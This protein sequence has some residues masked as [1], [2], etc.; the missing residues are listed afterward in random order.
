MT[1][2]ELL[3]MLKQTSSGIAQE[4]EFF[5]TVTF[6]VIFASYAV[7]NKLGVFPRIVICVLYL[8]S[9]LIFMLRYE[10]LSNQIPLFQL[11]LAEIGSEYMKA[12]PAV[13]IIGILRRSIMVVGSIV[14]V[15]I[16]FRPVISQSEEK[17]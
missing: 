11:G 15:Y 14:T 1:E 6:A 4:F 3:E 17:D 5:L 2:F 16:V 9:V 12:P 8:S 7:G 10:I 13:P